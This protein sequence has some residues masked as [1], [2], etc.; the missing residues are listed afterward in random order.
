MSPQNKVYAIQRELADLEQFNPS[1]MYV[2]YI[3]LVG[4]EL[5]VIMVLYRFSSDYNKKVQQTI[6]KEIV[7]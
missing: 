3:M 4:G 1:E 2:Q 7:N 6:I 5:C